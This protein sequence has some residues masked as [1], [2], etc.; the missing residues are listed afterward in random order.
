MA[1]ET[2]SYGAMMRRMLRS[3]GKR[4]ADMDVAELKGL[5]DFAA[6]AERVTG[7]TVAK[8]R[9]KSGGGYSWAQIAQSLGISRS[10]AQHR[11]EKYG[12]ADETAEISR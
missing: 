8:L 2:A 9:S 1:V 11:Y 4:V 7:E 10:A 5:A 12:V 3:Y 6:D